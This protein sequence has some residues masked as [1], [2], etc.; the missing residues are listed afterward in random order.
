MRLLI[1]PLLAALIS[2]ASCSSTPA[3][4]AA[5]VALDASWSIIGPEYTAYVDADVTKDADQKAQRK[6][7]A[8]D[9]AR[10]IAE[11]K[12]AAVAAGGVK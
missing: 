9:V 8:A 12:A 11:R 5:F 6:A 2:L 7:L 10:L 3:D 1:I 4:R